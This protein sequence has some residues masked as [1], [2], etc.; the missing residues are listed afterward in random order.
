M[1]LANSVEFGVK[2]IDDEFWNVESKGPMVGL[3]RVGNLELKE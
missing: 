1:G 2:S 3:A